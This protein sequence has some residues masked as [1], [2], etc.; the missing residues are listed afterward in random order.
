MVGSWGLEPQ[1][2]TVSK[3]RL[4]TSNDLG[5]VG[6]R[7]STPKHGQAGVLTGEI[8]G[9]K[10]H[11]EPKY[12]K[13]ALLRCSLLSQAEAAEK[14]LRLNAGHPLTTPEIVDVLRKSGMSLNSK[15]AVTIMYTTLNRNPKFERVADKA[16]PS[17]PARSSNN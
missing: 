15:N 7:L 6:D 16:L 3:R 1:T 5:N 8:A 11:G 9:E 17:L 14:L 12:A 10:F 4:C 2:S 13:I